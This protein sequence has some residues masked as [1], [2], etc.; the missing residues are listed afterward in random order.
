M[1]IL[2]LISRYIVGTTA[3][4]FVCT[5]FVSGTDKTEYIPYIGVSLVLGFV[6]MAIINLNE[7]LNTLEK[8]IEQ[9][10]KDKQ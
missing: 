2:L 10:E 9:L 5:M 1:D 8:K 4:F 6:Y 3:S 7:K